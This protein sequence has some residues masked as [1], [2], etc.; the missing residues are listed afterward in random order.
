MS[1]SA[2]RRSE[3]GASDRVHVTKETKLDI[4][5]EQHTVVEHTGLDEATLQELAARGGGVYQRSTPGGEE[6]VKVLEAIEQ[7]GTPGDFLHH[8][9]G[10]VLA[11]CTSVR[12]REDPE[13]GRVIRRDCVVCHTMPEPTDSF[14]SCS[15]MAAVPS[16]SAPCAPAGMSTLFEACCPRM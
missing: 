8:Y 4:L 9:H 11:W 5:R 3:D 10:V 16:I 1:T 15:G 2:L 6:L 12:V 14:E 7:R 13:D